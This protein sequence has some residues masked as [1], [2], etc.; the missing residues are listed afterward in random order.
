[1]DNVFSTQRPHRRSSISHL[2]TRIWPEQR[3][4]AFHGNTFR[5]ALACVPL[6][7]NRAASSG[8]FQPRE[9]KRSD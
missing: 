5:A 9:G 3:V 6:M 8:A 7:P 4:S 1:L 2:P